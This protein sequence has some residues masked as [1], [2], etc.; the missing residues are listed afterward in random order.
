MSPPVA[1]HRPDRTQKWHIHKLELDTVHWLSHAGSAIA[2]T[3]FR[4]RPKLA[5]AAEKSAHFKLVRRIAAGDLHHHVLAARVLDEE[6]GH[7]VH[8]RAWICCR[9]I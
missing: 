2:A 8:L 9:R 1:L 3:L 4:V 7:I 6:R 5:R